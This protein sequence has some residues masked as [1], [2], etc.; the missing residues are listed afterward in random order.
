MSDRTPE[1]RR[2][3]RLQ[4]LV[5]DILRAEDGGRIVA[6]STVDGFVNGIL[7]CDLDAARAADGAEPS[8]AYA[9]HCRLADDCNCG[10]DTPGVRE[11]C[12]NWRPPFSPP[13]S[14]PSGT[15][16]DWHLCCEP[17][18]EM[19]AAGYI[20]ADAE[21]QDLTP[22]EMRSIWFRMHAAIRR[23]A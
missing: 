10:G 2:F 23:D 4:M 12:V 20:D 7:A 15:H 16:P 1:D 11:G 8:G 5:Y 22:D 6:P 14:E 17:T 19:L 9:G 18:E 21:R 3:F 13:T